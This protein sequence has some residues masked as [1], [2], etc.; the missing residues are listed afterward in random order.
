MCLG[1]CSLVIL[2]FSRGIGFPYIIVDRVTSSTD[3]GQFKIFPFLMYFLNEVADD[4]QINC[5]SLTAVFATSISRLLNKC[6][7]STTVL[8]KEFGNPSCWLSSRFLP[9]AVSWQYRLLL[10]L[11]NSIYLPSC[12]ARVMMLEYPVSITI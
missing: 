8:R 11:L 2:P 6:L 1:S 3:M 9:G 10:L 12:M 5:C 4:R 7:F